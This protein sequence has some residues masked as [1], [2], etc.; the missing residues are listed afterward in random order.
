MAENPDQPLLKVRQKG[1]LTIAIMAATLLQVLDTTIA[2]VA[3]PHMQASLGATQDSIS[4]VLTSYIVASA[5]AIPITGWLADRI[6]S[7]R[8]FIVSVCTF[9]VASMLCGIATSLIEMVLFRLIQGI[10][11]AFIAPLAQSLLLDINRKSDHAKAMSIYGM[12]IMIGPIAGPILGGWLTENFNWRWVFYVNVPVGILCIAL[13]LWLLP[14]K[15]TV[16]RH[17]DATGFALLGL[18]LAALQLVLDRGEHVDWFNANEIWIETGIAAA[19][20]WMFGVHAFTAKSPLFPKDLWRDRNM[21]SGAIFMFVLGVLTMSA[22]ALL[23]PMLQSLFGYPVMETGTLLASRGMGVLITMFLVGRI[24]H[25]VD[26]RLMVFVGFVICAGSLWMMTGWSL[27]MDWVPVVESGFVQGLGLGLI[28]VPLNIL[29]F[30]TLHPAYRTDGASLLNLSRNIGSSIGIALMAALL[31]R[32][33]QIS[34]ADLAQHATFESLPLDPAMSGILGATGDSAMAMLNGE[35]T[36]QAAMI[37]YLDD[38]KLMTIATLLVL[39][40]IL[41]LKRPTPRKPG[42][43]LP[44][45]AE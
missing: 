29:S 6:G 4:W 38:F 8:L 42:D 14:S 15:E 36:R 41:L 18:G 24:S 45:M 44:V 1:L 16:K 17:F 26:L 13:L 9:V 37:A 28:F 19:A 11:G 32:N 35:V 31:T 39:P 25:F 34:H 30:A 5:I 40:L 21:V 20:F 3:L 7:R 22:M 2:N 10:S 23:P 43:E 27:E 33:T 12:G